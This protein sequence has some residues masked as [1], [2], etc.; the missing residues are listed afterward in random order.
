[1]WVA[2]L[3]ATL[4]APNAITIETIAGG[5]KKGGTRFAMNSIIVPFG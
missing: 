1:M 2:A 3:V 4:T 5:V